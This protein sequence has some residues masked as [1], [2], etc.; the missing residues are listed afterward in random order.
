M[1]YTDNL[2]Y[3]SEVESCFV[4]LSC[5]LVIP[6]ADF[7]LDSGTRYYVPFSHGPVYEL[8]NRGTE[9]TE[10]ASIGALGANKFFYDN[11]AQRLYF[12]PGEDITF[13][14]A[15]YMVATF[16][17]F[18]S[19][20]EMI[21]Y[22]DPTDDT[23][24]SVL[25]RALVKSQPSFKIT[26]PPKG[27]GFFPI[28][29][30]ALSI[31]NDHSLNYL[32]GN[33]SFRRTAVETWHRLGDLST[34]NIRKRLTGVVGLRIAISEESISFDVVDKSIDFDRQP[35]DIRTY[36]GNPAIDP[37]YHNTPAMKLI[38]SCG[39][40]DYY[41][42]LTRLL[43]NDGEFDPDHAAFFEMVNV[44]Y[45]AEAPTT[46][47]NRKFALLYD[48]NG[49]HSELSIAGSLR[50]GGGNTFD[51]TTN[52]ETLGLRAGERV[53]FDGAADQ[54]LEVA[55]LTGGALNNVTFTTVP[56][57]GANQAGNLR[58]APFDVYLI[59]NGVTP[60]RLYYGRDFTVTT[61]MS[62]IT[63]IT[64]GSSAESNVGAATFDPNTDA[65]WCVPAGRRNQVTF[66]GNPVGPASEMKT[67]DELLYQFL[68]EDCDLSE[69]EI[70]Y[71]S[72]SAIAPY[73]DWQVFIPNPIAQLDDYQPLRQTLDL[74]LKSLLL[75][76]YFDADGVFTVR[77]YKP[78]T[79]SD[80]TVDKEEILDG[81]FSYEIDYSEV[82]TPYLI[83]AWNAQA[84]HRL[85]FSG[86]TK[87]DIV[88]GTAQVKFIETENPTI[89][90]GLGSSSYKGLYLHRT[91][92][93]ELLEHLVA[94]DNAT[95]S[96]FYR[97]GELFGERDGL[98]RISGKRLALLQGSGDTLTVN[99]DSLPGLDDAT[100]NNAQFEIAEIE[101]GDT[102]TSLTL[103]DNKAAQ[104]KSSEDFWP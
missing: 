97:M 100:G 39:G 4:R 56:T 72:I 44:D 85:G 36:D 77:A 3:D 31:I 62:N 13:D 92:V 9:K 5:R 59:K 38:G 50:P 79:S 68:K 20:T 22:E 73:V 24:R 7:I 86:V 26:I 61:H 52:A 10:V 45:D 63:G 67:G 82:K 23:T 55:G 43:G 87:D 46:S 58:R 12:D 101:K 84:S 78:I 103:N 6:T 64:L 57:G 95:L 83:E 69:D 19:D 53:W 21:W 40:F 35:S 65:V 90:Q 89:Q 25:W 27:L 71:D 18:F 99:R 47:N 17:L 74:L 16:Y 51:P 48:P 30:T 32:L 28:E 88:A 33:G 41:A 70:D 37:K 93:E 11:D 15:R 102:Q 91:E 8:F 81:S 60:Y 14:A 98:M 1:S 104:D 76:G 66:G 94:K 80:E 49:Y 2:Q 29:P 42:Q 54:Y 96:F 34:G 75:R